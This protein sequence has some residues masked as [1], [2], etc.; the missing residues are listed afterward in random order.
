MQQLQRLPAP[1][2]DRTAIQKLFG[3]SAR[4]SLRILHQL[5]GQPHG[6]ALVLLRDELLERLQAASQSPEAVHERQRR[7]RLTDRLEQR[8]WELQAR[9]IELP[10]PAAGS[11]WETLRPEIEFSGRKLTVEFRDAK[12]L[13]GKLMQVAK[14][15]AEDWE[16]FERYAL[17][18]EP[19]RP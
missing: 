2:L 12:D 9:R 15:A 17:N 5:G 8:K 3:V 14:L 6:G 11:T 7:K 4:Q 10:A 13:M 16:G 19:D 1:V 18:P